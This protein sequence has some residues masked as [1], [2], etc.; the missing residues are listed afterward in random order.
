[1]SFVELLRREADRRVLEKIGESELRRITDPLLRAPLETSLR[2]SVKQYI[3]NARS[4]NPVWAYQSAE[5]L[6]ISMMPE[7]PSS[8]ARWLIRRGILLGAE[9]CKAIG[10]SV[11]EEFGF[12]QAEA[13][14][15]I[16]KHAIAYQEEVRAFEDQ[17]RTSFSHGRE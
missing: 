4:N 12:T 15:I 17:Y 13:E 7:G 8:F 14:N 3:E 1:M 2:D 6:L 10:M 11:C 5:F 16:R 9:D